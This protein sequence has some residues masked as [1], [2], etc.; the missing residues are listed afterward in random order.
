MMKKGELGS[1]TL[2]VYGQ[3][4]TQSQNHTFSISETMGKNKLIGSGNLRFSNN[5]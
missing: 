4:T 1:Y 3:W 2:N 5:N